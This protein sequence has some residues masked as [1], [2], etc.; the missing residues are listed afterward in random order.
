MARW[1]KTAYPGVRYREHPK[2]KHGLQP[3]KYFCLHYKIDG[4]VHDEALG[5]ASQ[6]W[7]ATKA[8]IE[9]AKLKQAHVTGEGAKTLKQRREQAKEKANKEKVGKLTF[10]QFFEETYYPQAQRD[11]KASSCRREDALYR[12][13][14]A[15]ILGK[16]P[17]KDVSP[18]HLEKLKKRMDDAGQSARSIQYAL[19]VVRQVF[20]HARGHTIYT[21]DNPVSKV[22]IPRPNNARLNFLTHEQASL[23]LDALKERSQQTYEMA[24]LAL[25][26]GLRF[27]EIAGLTWQDI[28]FSQDI[29]TIRDSKNGRTRHAYMTPQVRAMLKAKPQGKPGD[30]LFPGKD[31]RRMGKISRTFDRTVKDIGLNN[32]VTDPRM[33]LSFH[34][35]RHTFASWLVQSGTDLYV[36]QQLLGHRTN[37]MTQ[38]YAHLRQ[39]NLRQAVK[40]LDNA[41]NETVKLHEVRTND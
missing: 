35:L 36:V 18:F 28:D 23:L 9:L 40:Q 32:N 10:G 29:I 6:G 26:C 2:R 20:N 7:N 15:P 38:R 14:I 16:I 21:G 1:H 33:R 12:V 13:W 27:G 31:G 19:A 8:S 3:D 4:K 24:M 41:L 34:S 39:D 30:L 17:L 11:K 37:A 25:Y 5:W 22:K